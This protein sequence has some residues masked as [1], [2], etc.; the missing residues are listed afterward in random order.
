V[1]ELTITLRVVRL[2]KLVILA[3][4]SEEFAFLNSKMIEEYYLYI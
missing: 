1:R 2:K 3:S 4:K